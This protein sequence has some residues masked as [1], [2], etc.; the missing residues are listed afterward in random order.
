MHS[1]MIAGESA[2]PNH[3]HLSEL[4]N[5]FKIKNTEKI[6]KEVKDVIMNWNYYAD[7]NNVSTISKKAIA[8]I[9]CK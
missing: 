5:Y 2:N 4:G 7:K 9:I 6:I 1:T 8:K 3:K